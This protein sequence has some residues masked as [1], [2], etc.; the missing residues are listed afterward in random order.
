MSFFSTTVTARGEAHFNV[1][2][3]ISALGQ[4]AASKHSPS[5]GV[6]PYR[7]KDG[8]AIRLLAEGQLVNLAAAE[9]QLAAV[10]DTSFANQALSVLDLCGTERDWTL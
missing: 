10:M 6:E 3:N 8:R 1:E 2:I 5:K 9:G 4:L 7:L